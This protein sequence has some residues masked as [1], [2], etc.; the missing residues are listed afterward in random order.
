MLVRVIGFN[1][2]K[3]CV[4]YAEA[5]GPPFAVVDRN[6]ILFDGDAPSGLVTLADELKALFEGAREHPIDRVI[7]CG[8]STFS[9]SA[10]AIKGEAV[11]EMVACQKGLVVATVSSHRLKRDLGGKDK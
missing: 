11:V 8:R 5:E 2:L 9:S 6:R 4:Y 1:P 7:V 10:D 3:G